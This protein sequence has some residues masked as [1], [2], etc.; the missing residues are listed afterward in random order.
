MKPFPFD[1]CR[2]GS[3]T[4]RAGT[5]TWLNKTNYRITDFI[6]G[7]EKTVLIQNKHL[8][9][10]FFQISCVHTGGMEVTIGDTPHRVEAGN[11]FL[12]VNDPPRATRFSERSDTWESYIT[13]FVSS[14]AKTTRTYLESLPF[15]LPLSKKAE[16]LI[17]SIIITDPYYS[18]PG[19]Q[20][21]PGDE[22]IALTVGTHRDDFVMNAAR[23]L[24]ALVFAEAEK[25]SGPAGDRKSPP[26]QRA[27]HY[28]HHYYHHPMTLETIAAQAGVSRQHLMLLFR[29]A[30]VPSPMQYL[31]QKRADRACELL[32]HREIPLKEIAHECGFKTLDH[33]YRRI[34]EKTGRA[35]MEYRHQ[36]RVKPFIRKKE[37]VQES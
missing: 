26:L 25:I 3:C 2:F 15:S 10:H 12:L 22:Q 5:K 6:D 18:I 20:T 9:G 1:Y 29:K 32:V 7:K 30:G 27:L 19:S 33:L 37:S 21:K 31:W 17:Q 36:M 14:P 35:P 28:I 24:L 16:R 13:Y 23:A 8:S 34:K 4:A 11:I